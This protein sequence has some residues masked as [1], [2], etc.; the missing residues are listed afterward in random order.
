MLDARGVY[1]E[2]E[3]RPAISNISSEPG[4]GS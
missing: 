4:A 3:K 2:S 1:L